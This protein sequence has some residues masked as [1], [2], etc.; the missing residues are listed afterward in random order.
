[1]N[2]YASAGFNHCT[3]QPLTLITA[4]P[5]LKLHVNPKARPVVVHKSILS[6]ST[7]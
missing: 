5:H 4:T 3:H 6:L 7:G 2:Y 1:M